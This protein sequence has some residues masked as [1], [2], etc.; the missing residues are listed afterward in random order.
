MKAHPY[1]QH[2]AFLG[3]N[4]H[5]RYIRSRADLTEKSCV[6]PV[7]RPAGA[8]GRDSPARARGGGASPPLSLR[9]SPCKLLI[10]KRKVAIYAHI[11][12]SLIIGL[13]LPAPYSLTCVISMTCGG[14]TRKGCSGVPMM[15]AMEVPWLPSFTGS[16]ALACN[17]QSLA[18]R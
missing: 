11:M 9:L 15:I 6:V 8:P 4:P 2:S 13:T 17:S 5:S 3:P 12:R 10:P 16:I 14:W 7:P 18:G 1:A